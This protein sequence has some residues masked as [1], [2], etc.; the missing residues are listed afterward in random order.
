MAKPKKAKNLIPKTAKECNLSEEKTSDIVN[1]FYLELAEKIEDM[2]D[3]II[4][5]PVLG[6]MRLSKVKL[7]KSVSKLH[8]Y[9]TDSTK[10]TFKSM[11][12]YTRNKERYEHQKEALRIIKE[13]DNE[14]TKRKE[15]LGKQK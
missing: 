14:I 11:K 3:P 13:H 15:N 8:A 10:G 9:L 6:T 1:F 2:D 5:I 7:N 12:R 4:R